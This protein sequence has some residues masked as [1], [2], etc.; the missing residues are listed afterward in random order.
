MPT[1]QCKHLLIG[2]MLAFNNMLSFANE[3]TLFSLYEYGKLNVMKQYKY[4]IKKWLVVGTHT[5]TEAT[6][7]LSQV[8]ME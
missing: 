7:L 4:N 5:Y 8:L 6:E 3:N 2:T 1:I